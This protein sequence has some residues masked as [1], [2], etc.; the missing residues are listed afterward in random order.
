MRHALPKTPVAV[1]AGVALLAAMS[2]LGAQT[3]A[4]ARD[5]V[6]RDTLPRDTVR[7][8]HHPLMYAAIAATAVTMIAAPPAFM[9]IPSNDTTGEGGR[10]LLLASSTVMAYSAVG[11]GND[12]Q[13]RCLWAL[14]QGIELFHRGLYAEARL[15]Q[16]GLR[17][18][19]VRL[20]TMRLGYLAHRRFM[21]GGATIGVRDPAP[22]GG[23]RGV[24]LALPLLIGGY[25]GQMRLEP[26]YLI[27]GRNVSWNYR[28]QADLAVPRS[29]LVGGIR[30]TS[31]A[32]DG[33]PT[34]SN[35]ALTF[36]IGIR[37]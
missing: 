21:M 5:T 30:I 16:F 7:H 26:L 1:L 32:F 37:R 18:R 8:L 31:H 24:E 9:L 17:D 3:P 6:R 19:N 2:P 22:G 20:R 27:S 15:E 28:F 36:L 25:G 14:A 10:T 33:E 11:S 4:A 29:P 12:N 35:V 23:L 34:E 13:E